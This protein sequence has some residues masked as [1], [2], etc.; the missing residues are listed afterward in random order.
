[1]MKMTRLISLLILA[2]LLA[3]CSYLPSLDK[4]MP[5]RR[6]EYEKAKPMPDLEIPP[7]LTAEAP[8]DS[9]SIPG[10][11]ASLSQYQRAH[12]KQSQAS[13]PTAAA[14][15]A[16]AQPGL[17]NQQWVSVNGSREAIWPKLE[18]FFKDKGYGLDLNDMDLGVIETTWSQPEGSGADVHRDKYRIVTDAG[19]SPGVTVLFITNQRQVQAGKSKNGSQ[20]LDQGKSIEAEKLLSGELNMY[21]NGN[22][23]AGHTVESDQNNSAADNTGESG[24]NNPAAGHTAVPN[25]DKP[26][27]AKQQA[28]LQDTGGN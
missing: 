7:D 24:Q 18:T 2:G 22:S 28:E 27:A 5:D 25:Q 23:D 1:M 8:N 17:S 4:V 11:G 6:T 13:A 19:A 14:A 12:A 10:E 26:D 20:W 15:A 21:L 3:G 16:P 9:T